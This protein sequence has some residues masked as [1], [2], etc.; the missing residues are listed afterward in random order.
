[1]IK[2]GISYKNAA[3]LILLICNCTL[4]NR[5]IYVDN[6]GSGDFN[7]I[8]AAI[9]DANDGDIILV[10]DGTYTGDGN[11]DIDF[12][13]KAITLKSQNGA[14]KCIIDCNGSPNDPHRGF[15][16]H[17]QEDLNSVL[18]GFTI[19]GGHSGYPIERGGG[20]SCNESSPQIKDC[21]LTGNTAFLGGGIAI[22][23]SSVHIIDC[24]IK[25]NT[26]S[27]GGGGISTGYGST[28]IKGCLIE[29]NYAIFDSGVAGIKGDGGG[30][31]IE[32]NNI[33]VNIIECTVTG[34]HGNGGG[35]FL[36]SG[37]NVTNSIIY[38]NTYDFQF[39]TNEVLVS[40]RYNNNTDDRH[41]QL[42]LSPQIS[43][44]YCLV[45]KGT[46]S[47]FFFSYPEDANK[48]LIGQWIQGDP[49]FASEGYWDTKGTF[50]DQLDDVWADGDYHLKSQA[51][52]WNPNSQS[53]VIDDVTSPCIDAG[54]PNSPIGLEPFP[55]GGFINMGAY[56]GTSEAS[57]SYF[58]KPV[59]TTIVAGDING[60]CKVD[61]MDIMILVSHWLEEH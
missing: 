36:G 17:S 19:T 39:Y 16:F 50:Y 52:R 41:P 56:G 6:N 18:Q 38:G 51:G 59:C 47:D 34:N 49:C 14:E 60:D 11:R 8:Q 37:A 9:D 35:I 48:L 40:Y 12:K 55:N 25:K 15:Y 57:K 26:A 13:G 53:W 32:R 28:L 42:P 61:V 3:I 24:I 44:E 1:M 30:I 5:T 23:N 10:A 2:K 4:A 27:Y 45:G 58:G 20:I 21:V 22:Y 43:I 29:G 46:E 31:L 54:D 33:I 7:N